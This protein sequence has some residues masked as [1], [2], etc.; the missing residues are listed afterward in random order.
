M[1]FTTSSLDEQFDFKM[2]SLKAILFDIQ[3][4]FLR[5]EIQHAITL[6]DPSTRQD[7]EVVYDRII[8]HWN[9]IHTHMGLKAEL[10]TNM[11]KFYMFLEKVLLAEYAGKPCLTNKHFVSF[12]AGIISQHRA[13]T[14]RRN[15]LNNY[16][17]CLVFPLEQMLLN[18]QH[19]ENRLIAA[20][21]AA[22]KW[23]SYVQHLIDGKDW[24]NLATT[25][26]N[27]R[28]LV[29]SL[30]TREPFYKTFHDGESGQLI[31]RGIDNVESR[32]LATTSNRSPFTWNIFGAVGSQLLEGAKKD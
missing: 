14:I 30:F 24:S 31:L 4:P 7:F 13:G 29:N 16:H 6:S 22:P 2:Q 10:L 3:T 28:D 19:V 1:E 20:D 5:K 8:Q 27:D 11:N 12:W 17:D 21:S 32:Y 23:N 9:K 26:K 15:D 18:Q 25:V